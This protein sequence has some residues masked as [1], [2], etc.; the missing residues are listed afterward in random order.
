MSDQFQEQLKEAR[1][2][3]I[4]DAAIQV[5]SDSGFERTTIKQIARQAGIADGTIYNYFKNK[6]AILHAIVARITEAEVRDIH[7]AEA[8]QMDFSTFVKTY[9]QHRAQELEESIGILKAILPETMT[10]DDIATNVYETVYEPAFQQAENYIQHLMDTG[11]L[12]KGNAKMLARVFASPLLGIV[13]L[14]LIGDTHVTQHWEEY[15]QAI[16]DLLL[17]LEQQPSDD[18]SKGSN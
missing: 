16:I 3:L 6:E 4:I 10:R 9:V 15:T 17:T 5:I 18:T 13:M 12:R 11:R 1:R 14:R 7:F 2:N 8:Q